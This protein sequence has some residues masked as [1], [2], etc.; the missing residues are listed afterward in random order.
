GFYVLDDYAPLRAMAGG[1]MENESTL[2]PVRD[3][4]W[5]IPLVPMQAPGRPTLGSDA[6]V[7]PNPPF[8]ATFTYYLD[9]VPPTEREAR[10]A[11]E[12]QL[13]ER[14]DDVPF[15]GYDQ[16][17]REAIEQ[18]PATLLVVRDD[19]GAPVRWVKGPAKQGLHRVS[20]D[21]RRPAPDPV[22]F[23]TSGFRPPWAGE[24]QG[25]LVAPGRYEVELFLL[26]SNGLQPLS[27]PQTF[28]VKPVPTASPGTDFVAVAAF[29]LE[30]AELMRRTAG[31]GE[32][33]G[34]AQERLRYMRAALIETPGADPALFTRIDRLVAALAAL[35]TRLS[36]DRVRGQLS[37]SSAPS[38]SS[39]VGQVIGGHWETRQTP[40]ATQ[41][42]NIEVAGEDFAALRRELTA[43][44]DTDLAQ[45]ESALEAAGAPWIPGMRIPR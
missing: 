36:G 38:I 39:R 24:P 14:G 9:T 45:L 28:T 22:E 33:V 16:L 44:I 40:T 20:W 41:R 17:A 43:L 18:E 29:Q 25:P 37:E 42:R 23:P 4:W 21:L 10:R 30:T 1:G 31:A 6:Y 19:Q 2:F 3:A 5:Y 27:T 8:G 34:E 12:R 11:A 35:Q 32:E 7:T 15:P 26:S 13:T